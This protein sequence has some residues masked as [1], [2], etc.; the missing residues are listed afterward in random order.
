MKLLLPSK[1]IGQM[2]S[3][4]R[5]R[6][7]EIGGVLVGEHVNGDIFRVVDLS[8]QLSGG[9]IAHFVRDHEHAQAFIAKFFAKT[10]QQYARFN[11]L[12][13]WHSHPL[14]MAL[15]SP[16]DHRSM[17]G[18]LRNSK[19]GVDFVVLIIARLGEK[20]RVEI[21]ATL[22]RKG[23]AASEVDIEIEAPDSDN[24]PFKR[25]LRFITGG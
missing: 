1:L 24:T 21:S 3:K 10:D 18:I 13:E 6:S 12:G 5:G 22:F 2:R 15:P 7:Y 9:S 23:L 11:Y 19:V 25:L 20:S 14:F 17:E 4:L 16:E 8:F